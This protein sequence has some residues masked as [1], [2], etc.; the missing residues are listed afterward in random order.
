MKS[1]VDKR[2]NVTDHYMD[3][4]QRTAAFSEWHLLLMVLG[5]AFRQQR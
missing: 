5:F 4:R 2:F 1:S 3:Q